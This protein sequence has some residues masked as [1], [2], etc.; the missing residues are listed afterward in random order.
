M[1][2]KAIVFKERKD[3]LT[4]D[5]I[6]R[7]VNLSVEI[8]INKIKITGGEPL[9]RKD[10]IFL[11]DR[12]TKIKGIE[13]ISLTTNG[14]LLDE[15]VAKL[16]ES[17]LRRLNISLDTLKEERFRFITKLGELQKVL[18][19][20][21]K[22]KKLGMNPVKI[23]TVVIKGI[24]DDEIF[25]FV[26]FGLENSCIV[27]FIEYMPT[28]NSFGWSLSKF[29]SIDEIKGKCSELGELYP[30][31]LVKGGGPAEYFKIKVGN[32]EGIIGFINPVSH[33][34]CS[35]CNRLRLTADGK[36]RSC[37]FAIDG[38]NLKTILRNGAS[39]EEIKEAIINAIRLK[40]KEHLFDI[41]SDGSI[42]YQVGG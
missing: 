26:R 39:D 9:V 17:G 12:L 14:I 21:V 16:K 27:R 22:A 23:N 30:D 29:V 18:K 36:L 19:G 13:D 24:N 31:V 42:M 37:L 32:K 40:P 5:E 38:I 15:N 4:Y 33:H 34:F 7:I 10:I 6:I 1:P 35:N 3:I 41:V 2:E 11:I 8:G 28:N 20:I 25:D